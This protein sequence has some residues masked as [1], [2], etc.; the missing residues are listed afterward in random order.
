MLLKSRKW[1]PGKQNGKNIRVLYTLPI[2]VHA[3]S[4]V[5]T[6]SIKAPSSRNKYYFENRLNLGLVT[7]F[8]DE[9]GRQALSDRF[10]VL[11]SAV[12]S[13]SKDSLAQISGKISYQEI[14]DSTGKCSV[15]SL[16]TR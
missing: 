13:F 14:I 15:V 8:V 1:Y 10:T 6:K 7:D 9:D 5:Q 12:N 4:Y 16:K 11:N 2:R 3:S